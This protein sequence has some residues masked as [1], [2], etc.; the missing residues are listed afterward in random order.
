MRGRWIRPGF[1]ESRGPNGEMSE[2]SPRQYAAR[3]RRPLAGKE[4]DCGG[5]A[6]GRSA[7][8]P[9]TGRTMS[10]DAPVRRSPSDTDGRHRRQGSRRRGSIGLQIGKW[11][12]RVPGGSSAQ[13]LENCAGS[14]EVSFADEELRPALASEQAKEPEKPESSAVSAPS[15]CCDPHFDSGGLESAA[16]KGWIRALPYLDPVLALRHRSPRPRAPLPGRGKEEL[17]VVWRA[18]TRPRP[19]RQGGACVLR[20]SRWR[21]LTHPARPQGAAVRR[22]GSRA[23][24]ARSGSCLGSR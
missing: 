17:E 22:S 19:R 1:R 18:A 24:A 11:P 16:G 21:R 4:G 13:L 5:A 2:Q 14:L 12:H 23:G 8:P 3:F 15:G 6:P 9:A 20:P 7:A 10:P